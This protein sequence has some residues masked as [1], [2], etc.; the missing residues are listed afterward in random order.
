MDVRANAEFHSEEIPESPAVKG[1]ELEREVQ[2]AATA[3]DVASQVLGCGK[4]GTVIEIGSHEQI[5]SLITGEQ[6]HFIDPDTVKRVVDGVIKELHS[7]KSKQIQESGKL[8]PEQKKEATSQHLDRLEAQREAISDVVLYALS[9]RR[10]ENIYLRPNVTPL[11]VPIAFTEKGDVIVMLKTKMGEEVG[12]GGFKVVKNAFSLNFNE[13]GTHVTVQA[14]ASATMSPS[15]EKDK[16][17]AEIEKKMAEVLVKEAKADPNDKPVGILETKQ[18]V[19]YTSKKDSN[20]QKTG[21]ISQLCTGGDLE[22]RVASRSNSIPL[23]QRTQMAKEFL[24]GVA[25]MHR[26]GIAHLDLKPANILLHEGHVKIAD[27]GLAR[28]MKDTAQREYVNGDMTYRSPEVSRMIQ[29]FADSI[30]LSH[31]SRDPKFAELVSA[32][33]SVNAAVKQE[34]VRQAS[35]PVAIECV[36]LLD[37]NNIFEAVRILVH[38]DDPELSDQMAHRIATKMLERGDIDDAR[39]MAGEISDPETRATMLLDI[40]NACAGSNKNRFLCEGLAKEIGE[41]KGSAIGELF[42]HLGYSLPSDA[43]LDE[44]KELQV[45]VKRSTVEELE[46]DLND[47]K[48]RLDTSKVTLR[49]VSGERT[50]VYKTLRGNSFKINDEIYKADDY[51]AG[52]ILAQLYL[53]VSQLDLQFLGGLIP[54]TSENV[55]RIA[56]K[57]EARKECLSPEMRE[58]IRGLMHPDPAKRLTA[59][60]AMKQIEVLE[61]KPDGIYIKEL[62]QEPEPEPVTQPQSRST[63]KSDDEE[64]VETRSDSDTTQFSRMYGAAQ[65]ASTGYQ[66]PQAPTTGYAQ[67]TP[68]YQRQ[69]APATGYAM[70]QAPATGYQQPQAEPIYQRQDAPATGYAMPQGATTGYQQ[71]QAE[72]IYQRQDTPATGYQQPQAEPIYQRQDAP[73]TGYAMPQAPAAGYQ[74]PQAEPIYG[75]Q[76]APVTGY[77]MQQTPVTG[78][79]G[80]QSDTT[81]QSAASNYGQKQES[82]AAPVTRDLYALLS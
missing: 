51:A 12:R 70:P 42:S 31:G 59:A 73:A 1:Q 50:Q 21:V 43:H 78:Y 54:T 55:D 41:V 67:P 36:K 39:D 35:L 44:A 71:P 23:E 29:K 4:A 61:Q 33:Q 32:E 49:K 2:T 82:P 48:V 56:A 74:Q 8:T 27:F 3:G 37:E 9:H 58:V 47:T 52:V 72:P 66:V 34:T 79:H 15:E 14:E 19:T 46:K 60:E 63:S 65:P 17:A 80:V 6:I 18:V 11:K 69:D 10:K 5:T 77:G 75:Q 30:N 20:I 22:K 64:P 24:G 62:P 76:D 53:G 45:P 68:V 28:Y 40:Y 7:T 13:A 25:W 26:H 38:I 57:I 16:A 81:V